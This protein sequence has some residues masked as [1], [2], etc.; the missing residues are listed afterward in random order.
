[1]T[2]MSPCGWCAIVI[3]SDGHVFADLVGVSDATVTRYKAR[4]VQMIGDLDAPIEHFDLIDA[5]GAVGPAAARRLLEERYAMPREALVEAAHEDAALAA[6][7]DGIHRFLTEDELGLHPALSKTAARKATRARAYEVVRRSEAWGRLLSTAFP[8]ALRL[9]IHPQPEV[10]DKLGIHLLPT[11]DEWLTPWHGA[12]LVEG[13]R[14]R[15][16][17]RAQAEA[18]GARVILGDQGQP[19]HLE[20]A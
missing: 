2:P 12:V 7:I 20:A 18:A 1:M 17:K 11:E 10:S 14:V 9:S 3:C 19:S 15:L 4:L 6:Q 8:D 13:T 16:V 5:F